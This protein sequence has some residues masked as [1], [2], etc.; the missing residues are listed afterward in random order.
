[1]T[2]KIKPEI[3][4]KAILAAPID[5]VWN[6][7][8][9]PKHIINWNFASDEWHT[10]HAENDLRVGGKFSYR[11]EAKDKSFGF[12]F[13]GRYTKVETLKEISYTLDD[14]R[15]VRIVF[16]SEGNK[17]ILTETFEAEQENSLDLQKTGWQAILDNFVKYT[18][19]SQ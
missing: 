8:T 5:K 15:K 19:T 2:T 13:G 1:M 18:K 10:P 6:C 7:F 4:V 11:M 12:D 16:S 14:D 9:E 3:T 17:T